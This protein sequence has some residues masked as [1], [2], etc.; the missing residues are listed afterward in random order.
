MN[1]KESN[2]KQNIIL[3]LFFTIV[4]NANFTDE[5]VFLPKCPM[6]CYIFFKLLCYRY[7]VFLI[8]EYAHW[9][10]IGGMNA[11]PM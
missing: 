8:Y 1:V 2:I 4:L 10:T 3:K 9:L 11:Q 6:K 5:H 7:E